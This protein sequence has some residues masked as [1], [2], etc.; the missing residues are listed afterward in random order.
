MARSGE[1][2]AVGV[3]G[4]VDS[5]V[6][7]LLLRD[8]GYGVRGV[9][10]RLWPGDDPRSC[11]S[12]A[13]ERRA[14]EAAGHLGLPFDVLDLRAEFEARVVEPFVTA[15]LAGLTPNPCV[16]CNPFRFARLR[17][18]AASRGVALVSSGHYAAL[19]CHDGESWLRRGRDAGKDQSYMVARVPAEI[20]AAL[21]LPLGELSKREVR[22]RARAAGLALADQQESQEVCFACDGYRG[23]LRERGVDPRPGEIVDEG[24][25]RLGDHQGHWE[26][27]VGQRRGLGVAAEHPLFVLERR[28]ATNQVVVGPRERLSTTLVAVEDIDERGEV[29]LR[30][31]AETP[32]ELTVQLRYRSQAVPVAGLERVRGGR[33]RVRLAAPFE[34][35]AAGQAAVFYDGQI[36]RAVGSLAAISGTKGS[37]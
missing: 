25:V 5:A 14:A 18:W 24:G 37:M 28:A 36:V 9:F 19:E 22:E 8:A 4:G 11:C 33:L 16:I 20:L 34:A 2:V 29:W 7:A 21:L 32:A 27:T 30:S 3:S 15:Y 31:C 35:P 10:L 13:A 1:A 6:A 17:E 26:F 23:F 12:P